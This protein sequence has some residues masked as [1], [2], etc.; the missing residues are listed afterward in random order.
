MWHAVMTQKSIKILRVTIGIMPLNIITLDIMTL[1]MTFSEMSLGLM[2][3]ERT[4]F[5]SIT[6]RIKSR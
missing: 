5:S 1:S 6:F 4:I 2:T 3:L